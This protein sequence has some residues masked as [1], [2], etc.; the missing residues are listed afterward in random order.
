MALNEIP[1][2]PS[3]LVYVGG[4]NFS[5][6]SSQSLN[7]VFNS[8]YQNYK[9]MITISDSSQV[10][11]QYRYR[12]SGAD[13]TTANMHNQY[14]VA[15][16]SS[17]AAGRTTSQ[18][19]GDLGQMVLSGLSFFDI[20]VYRPN[21]VATTGL[22]SKNASLVG[23]AYIRDQASTKDESTSFDGITIIPTSGTITGNIRVYGIRN[24]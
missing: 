3:S 9:I 10:V 21:E 6:V 15:D 4:A 17:A 18:T 16:G 23:G 1:L 20:T 24:S 8:R 2:L 11:L 14:L 5:A 22:I 19:I 12:A 13:N 7:N